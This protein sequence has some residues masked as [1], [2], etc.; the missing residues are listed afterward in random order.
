MKTGVLG[1]NLAGA[2]DL[3]VVASVG[4]QLKL[5]RVIN[6]GARAGPQIRLT[7]GLGVIDVNTFNANVALRERS[8]RALMPSPK[9]DLH[10]AL[11]TRA[12]PQCEGV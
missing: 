7:D 1:K 10:A 3:A 4:R 5:R 9:P 8:L 11:I 2:V 6:T 12:K